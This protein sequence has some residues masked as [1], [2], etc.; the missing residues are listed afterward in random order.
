MVI[1]EDQVRQTRPSLD[2]I[3]RTLQIAIDGPAG[4][5]KSTVA[6]RVADLLKYLYIDTGAM[7]RAATWLVAQKGIDVND[8]AAIADAVAHCIIELKPGDEQEKIHVFVDGNEVTKEIRSPQITKLVSPLSAIAA[9]RDKLVEQQRHMA[10]KG[11]V[12]LDGRDI[13][14][15]VLPDANVKIFLTASPEVRAQ[16]RLAELKAAGVDV[17]FDSLLKDIIERDHRDSNREIAPLRMAEDAV[18]IL[19]D[20]MTI[21]D[22]VSHI[23]KLCAE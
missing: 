5:G 11:G 14:T 21:D 19:S 10:L 1:A 13:G 6:K 23:I 12:V 16:R 15:V 18:L 4:A 17:E 22:V 7:Y 9:V 8:H 3:V 2:H 20:N